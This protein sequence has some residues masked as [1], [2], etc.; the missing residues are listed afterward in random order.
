MDIKKLKNF[1]KDKKVFVT[2][3]T[4]FK[5][6]WLCLFLD[7][8]GAKIIGYS[9]K[10]NYHDNYL[11]Y[12]SINL[13]RKIKSFY[14]DI[15]NK[16]KLFLIIKKHKPQIV[17]H[18][19]AQ[20]LVITSYLNPKNTFETN[21]LGTS[22]ILETCKSQKNIHSLI[23]A[24]SDKCYL[25]LGKKNNFDEN[26]PLGGNDPYSSSKAMSERLVKIYLDRVYKNTSIGLATVRAGNVIG[27][28]DF[29]ENRIVPDIFNHI[30]KK[31][32]LV[33]RNPNSYRP[34]QH[35]FDVLSGYLN[36]AIKLS[37]NK[38]K[39]SGPYNF[40]PK[41]NKNYTV[42]NLTKKLLGKLIKNK[43]KIIYNKKNFYESNYLNI[44]SNK[45][46]TKLK[47]KT[48]Y[49]NFKMIQKTIEWYKVFMND[50]KKIEQFS[51]KQILDYFT[52][53]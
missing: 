42:L 51:K 3:H 5:G 27:G 11:F 44:N 26:S 23:I 50:Q 25:N 6:T 7:Y 52:N 13:N 24:T 21:V 12:K 41:N 34:W 17:F 4:G 1:Y 46:R 37:I 33:L 28:G 19:A 53:L 35:V 9:L 8:L 16:K 39:F 48:K 36:L 43:Y 32:K 49:S 30:I 31:K 22:N 2:G 40:G 20:S 14:G 45:S 29:S 38:N 47:W 18:L 10:P 15:L